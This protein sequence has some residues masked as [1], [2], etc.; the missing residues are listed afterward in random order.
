MKLQIVRGEYRSEKVYTDY[1]IT[2]GG[3]ASLVDSD[4]KFLELYP[5][6][7]I[8]T[9]EAVEIPKFDSGIYMYHSSFYNVGYN[10]LM[11]YVHEDNMYISDNK[12]IHYGRLENVSLDIGSKVRII[13]YNGLVDKVK[14][15][16][17]KVE[18]DLIYR[19]SEIQKN[20]VVITDGKKD[21]LLY[22]NNILPYNGDLKVGQRFIKKI[23]NEEIF[24]KIK[25]IR[26][27]FLNSNETYEIDD[28]ISVSRYGVPYYNVKGYNNYYNIK[29]PKTHSEQIKDEKEYILLHKSVA[30]ELGFNMSNTKAERTSKINV[31]RHTILNIDFTVKS[32]K[33]K[34]NYIVYKFLKKESRIEKLKDTKLQPVR[35][36]DK[37]T[38][39]ALPYS[40]IKH[41]RKNLRVI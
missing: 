25:N 1:N 16:V 7:F 9:E 26:D 15:E 19:I 22:I 20:K 29:V 37:I 28:G 40:E 23:N 8:L 31:Y 13:N 6:D 3:I 2:D 35:I 36:T 39:Y 41:L 14:V 24:L 17:D 30:T 5:E 38:L 4:G 10:G 33:K 27:S 18:D 12:I 11:V 34:R 32:K 21:I